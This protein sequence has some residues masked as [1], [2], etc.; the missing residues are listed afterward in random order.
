MEKMA[1][2]FMAGELESLTLHGECGA[3]IKAWGR[4]SLADAWVAAL[5]LLNDAELVHKDPEFDSVLGLRALK[6]PYD[7]DDAGRGA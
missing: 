2:L 1:V 3:R 6:L 5:A 7:R 4:I